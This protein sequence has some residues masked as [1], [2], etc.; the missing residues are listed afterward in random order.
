MKSLVFANFE[1]GH[2]I[3]VQVQA[4]KSNSGFR[5]YKELHRSVKLK[6]IES[7]LKMGRMPF[8]SVKH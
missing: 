1:V 2:E 7:L 6:G 5:H 4:H 8:C 3:E